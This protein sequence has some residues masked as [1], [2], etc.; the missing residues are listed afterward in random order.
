MAGWT[1]PAVTNIVAQSLKLLSVPTVRGRYFRS[2]SGSRRQ[3]KSGTNYRGPHSRAQAHVGYYL[4]DDGREALFARWIHSSWIDRIR[5]LLKGHRRWLLHRRHFSG[6]DRSRR[7][8]PIPITLLSAARLGLA[9][10]FA[11]IPASQGA[12]ELVNHLVTALFNAPLPKL[13]YG[14]GLPL[15]ATTLVAVPALLRNGRQTRKLVNDIEVRYL[16]NRDNNLHFALLTDL[17]DSVEEPRE[18]D[19]HPLVGLAGQL[20][21]D[22]NRKY[23]DFGSFLLLH[24][25]RIFNP[26]QGVWMG[27]ERKRGKLIDL[28]NLLRSQNDNFPVRVGDLSILSK[29]KYV[30]T[31][32][33]DT[34]LPHGAAAELV[35]TI[36]HPLNRAIID[37]VRRIVRAG[38]GILQPRVGVSVNRP[39]A[40]GWPVCIPGRPG[41]MSTRTLSLMSTR[42]YMVRASLPA[43]VSTKW[44]YCN[45]CSTGAS[46]AISCSAT[47]SSKASMP[48][49][50]W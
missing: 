17:P 23:P 26:K 33:S 27:W 4:I 10:L 30:L 32:D 47:T 11:L 50:G 44:M 41:L 20:I 42:I 18:S 2:S 46:R 29:V 16:G 31:L 14:D 35:G 48:A 21:L 40:R 24:R 1:M 15:E 43:K 8:H 36:C 49:P 3:G 5:S 34:Q 22:L 9:F 6:I 37:P 25:H 12:V 38:Y 28:N 7:D 45:R 19:A 13:D 39:P